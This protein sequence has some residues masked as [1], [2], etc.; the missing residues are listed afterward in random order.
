MKVRLSLLAVAFMAFL[1][2]ACGNNEK[3]P[4]LSANDKADGGGGAGTDKQIKLVFWNNRFPSVDSSDKT[5]KKEDFYIYQAIQRFEDSHP[6][7]TI[8]VQAFPDDISQVTKFRTASIAANGPDVATLWTGNY[9]LGLKNYLEPMNDYFSA[10]ELS[11]IQGWDA[12]AE[13]LDAK[14]GQIYGVPSSS[15]GSMLLFYSKKAMLKAGVDDPSLYM[16]NFDKFSELMDKLKTSGITPISLD[17]TTYVFHF[18]SYWLAQTL[19]P[20]GLADLVNKKG[21]NFSDPEVVDV[22]DKWGE[23][24]TKGYLAAGSSNADEGQATQLFY[25]GKAAMITGGPW[26]VEDFQKAMGDDLGYMRFPD[27]SEKAPITNGGL[28][29]AGSGWV[30]TEYSAHK[31][32]AVEFI[33]FMMSKEEKEE[34]LKGQLAFIVNVTD[35]DLSKFTDNPIM[36]Y[37]QERASSPNNI[38]WP[39]NVFPSELSAEISSLASLAIT[40]KMSPEDFA[41]KL[42]EKRDE[43]LKNAQ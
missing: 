21:H 40:G 28:G 19:T 20:G 39:D 41:K 10:D 22:L 8:D 18:L 16:T 15:D 36:L 42:D 26:N 3:L 17:K 32:E 27:I 12:V 30:V 9:L 29:G 1:L 2:S 23:L 14:Q 7:V 35:V 33:K 4:D 24:G 37:M 43:L 34:Q 5:K 31:K 11:R 13:G 38:F 6:G 25:T